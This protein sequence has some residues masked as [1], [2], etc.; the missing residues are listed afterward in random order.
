ML[1]A[2]ITLY[3]NTHDRNEYQM[4]ILKITIIFTTFQHNIN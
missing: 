4:N 3:N 2:Y 1:F